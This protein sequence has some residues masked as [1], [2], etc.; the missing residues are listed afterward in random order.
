MSPSGRVY[1]GQTTKTLLYRKGR[2]CYHAFRKNYKEYDYKIA[3]A[4]R[5]YGD[6]LEWS[7]LHKSIP[8]NNLNRLEIDEIKKYDSFNSGYNS[9]KGGEGIVGWSHSEETKQK[10][11]KSL[12]GNER[13]GET[14]EKLSKAHTGK[15]LSEEHKRKIS[16]NS[17]ST[18]LNLEIAEKIREE[19]AVG[20]YTIG[21][22][23][24]KYSADSRTIRDIVNN[25]RWKKQN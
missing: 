15:K 12:M 18:K 10:I 6:R 19:Y 25:L 3:R 14:R 23:A 20:K 5:K 21:K 8:T 22:L 9:T 24:K 4:I 2:H 16:E 1:I 11:S 13:S 17:K 7:I